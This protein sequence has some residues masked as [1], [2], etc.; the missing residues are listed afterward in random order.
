MTE[1][2]MGIAE[3]MEKLAKWEYNEADLFVFQDIFGKDMGQ[4]LWGKFKGYD[5]S[6][7]RLWNSLDIEKA[8]EL[9][10][11]LETRLE[12]YQVNG[13]WKR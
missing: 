6:I 9:A 10:R 4:H 13:W 5:S 8:E 11:A 1:D 12:G 3:I 7:L 2:W